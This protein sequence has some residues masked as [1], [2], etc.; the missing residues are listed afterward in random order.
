MKTIKRYLTVE[1][2]GRG[3]TEADASLQAHF[4][5]EA[6]E[7]NYHRFRCEA[8]PDKFGGD[9]REVQAYVFRT[10]WQDEEETDVT[11]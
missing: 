8:P 2:I 1:I 6:I 5:S 9:G 7:G 3:E 11:W 10:D 4:L